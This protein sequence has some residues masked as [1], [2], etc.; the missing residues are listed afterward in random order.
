M[1]T[2]QIEELTFLRILFKYPTSSTN[3]QNYFLVHESVRRNEPSGSTSSNNFQN[4][5]PVH[6]SVRRNEPSGSVG[7]QGEKFLDVHEEIF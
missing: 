1:Y 4:Y 7:A 3:F 5:F 2:V 6:E